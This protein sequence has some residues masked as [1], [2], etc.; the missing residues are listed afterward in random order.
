[1]VIRVEI[2]KL[3]SFIEVFNCRNISRAADNLF[4]SQSALSR[5]IQSLEMEFNIQL[6]ER[7]GSGLK[8]TE[9][10]MV[11]YKE[12]V[13]ILRQCDSA[14][15][16]MNQVKCGSGGI[17]RVGLLDSMALS[18][19]M[20]AVSK[21]QETYPDLE[22]VFDS[23]RNT[24]VA[25]RLV[26]AQIDVGV[27]VYGEISGISDMDYEILGGNTMAALIG[28]SHRLWKKRPLY[29]RDLDGETLFYLSDSVE[30]AFASVEQYCKKQ[31]VSFQ[32][33]VPCRSIFEELLYTATGKGV[34]VIGVIASE[35]FTMAR[36]VVDVVPLEDTDLKQGYAVSIYDK[37]NIN[38]E[39]FVS[40]LKQ[41]W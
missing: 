41:C 22:I 16:K 39:N 27:T 36:D 10:A 12:A 21:M 31:K 26:N 8:P 34:A 5:R 23:D 37:G 17:L 40:I 6:F 29:L 7:D 13:K 15:I 11:L 3:Q 4:I 24:N 18:P 20:R 9:A 30:Q 38:A 35:L 28:R 19:T 14:I 1:M 33:R 2:E 25:Y 32:N